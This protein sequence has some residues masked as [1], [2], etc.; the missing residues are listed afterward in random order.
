MT[1][2]GGPRVLVLTAPVDP[3][4]DMVLTHLHAEGVPFLRVDPADFPTAVN[5]VGEITSGGRW[6]ARLGGV[7]LDSVETVYYRRPG[8][9]EFDPAIP[10]DMIEWCEGQARFGFWGC[11]NRC[12]PC[13]STPRARCTGPSTSPGSSPTPPRPA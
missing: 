9:F 5:L 10:L 1:S 2:S 11:S 12:P 8:R 6:D 4:A 13:G 3:T 7:A